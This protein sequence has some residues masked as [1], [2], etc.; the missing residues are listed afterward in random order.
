M[1]ANH[2]T[3]DRVLHTPAVTVSFL[4]WTKEHDHYTVHLQIKSIFKCAKANADLP[5]LVLALV[6]SS[7][8]D[9]SFFEQSLSPLPL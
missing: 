3:A 9:T 7:A 2:N 5:A 6:P 4:S 8:S 1:D